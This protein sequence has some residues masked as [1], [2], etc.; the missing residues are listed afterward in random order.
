MAPCMV[1]GCCCCYNA[2]DFDNFMLLCVR[3]SEC[4]CCVEEGCLALNTPSLG[5]GITTNAENKEC[6][7]ISLPCC[8]VGLKTPETCFRSAERCLCCKGASAFPF[9][10]LYVEKFVCAGC[11]G[12][13]CAPE[14]GCC[15]SVGTNTPALDRPLNDYSPL[16][17]APVAEK[18]ER[19]E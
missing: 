19:E 17:P 14:C 4:L 3:K 5:V 1:S 7:K 16:T 12:I 13:Q 18:V 10:E 11:Y 15:S 2:F 8:S 9:D 6:C